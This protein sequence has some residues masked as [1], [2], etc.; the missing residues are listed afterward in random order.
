MEVTRHD[1]TLQEKR[2]RE[3]RRTEV[4]W[5]NPETQRRLAQ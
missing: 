2:E 1:I 4:L 5:R 3:K